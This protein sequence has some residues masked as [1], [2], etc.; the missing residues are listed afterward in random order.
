MVTKIAVQVTPQG[1]LI[2]RDAVG[3]WYTREL[4]AVL[5]QRKITIRPRT[6]SSDDEHTRTTEVLREAGMMYE[7]HWETPSYVSPEERRR[8]AK[9][10]GEGQPLSEVIIA[11]REDR[12]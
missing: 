6:T 9:K 3:D 1:L 8:L 10:L 4:E 7:P 5:E 12:A 2:P 11:D